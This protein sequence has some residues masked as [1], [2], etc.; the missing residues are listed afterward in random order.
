[1][2]STGWLWIYL[3]GGG[4]GEPSSNISGLKR[5]VNSWSHDK[6]DVVQSI[7]LPISN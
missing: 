7:H 3:E 2:D 4:L 1:M 6:V 5:A